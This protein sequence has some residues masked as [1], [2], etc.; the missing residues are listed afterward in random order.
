[1]SKLEELYQT[2]LLSRCE[3]ARV[4]GEAA[5]WRPRGLAAPILSS[6][7]VAHGGGGQRQHLH[8]YWHIADIC[9]TYGH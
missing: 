5:L 4:R 9:M 3:V 1:M 6:A 7:A 8:E 2:F